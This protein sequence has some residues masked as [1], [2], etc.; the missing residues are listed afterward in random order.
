MKSS[1]AVVTNYEDYPVGDEPELKQTKRN[2][3]GLY[4]VL[5]VEYKQYAKMCV[6][7]IVLR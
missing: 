6:T 5:D 3:L 7:D 1:V 2:N 4:I